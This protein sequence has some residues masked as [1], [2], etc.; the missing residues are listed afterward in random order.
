MDPLALQGIEIGWECGDQGFP[1]AG[2]HFRDGTAVE[3]HTT[4]QLDVEVAHSQ[5]SP[6]RFAADGKG[7]DEQVV[8]R[9]AGRQTGAEL[10]GLL[11]KL[12]V[13]HGL[14]VRFQDIDRG[15]LRL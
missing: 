3:Y 9:F 10:F 14:V 13:G 7:L 4:H 2:D 11:A 5:G 12:R 8:E 15:D 1:F 6:T